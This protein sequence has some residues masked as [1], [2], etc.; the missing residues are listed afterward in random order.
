MSDRDVH[1]ILDTSALIEFAGG[2]VSVGE[3]LTEVH[4]TGGR[5]GIPVLCWSAAEYA[6]DAGGQVVLRMLVNHPVVDRLWTD[7]DADVLTTERDRYADLLPADQ[8][9]T[10]DTD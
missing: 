9:I 1:V 4:Q 5:I 6:I 3:M 8:V 7:D 2:S 10:I